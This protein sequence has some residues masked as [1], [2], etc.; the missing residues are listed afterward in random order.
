[1][2]RE[3]E[4]IVGREVTGSDFNSAAIGALVEIETREFQDFC[5]ATI[6]ADV[7]FL[8]RLVVDLKVDLQMVTRRVT[9]IT[10][11]DRKVVGVLLTKDDTACL[12]ICNCYVGLRVVVAD[13]ES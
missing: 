6:Q 1:M 12:D 9:E 8:N 3:V 5:V 11:M 2:Q 13:I 7:T 4:T 10:D